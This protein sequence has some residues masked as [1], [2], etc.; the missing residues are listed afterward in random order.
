MK[1]LKQ[2]NY[3]NKENKYMRKPNI[4]IALLS[5]MLVGVLSS[6]EREFD[7]PP[8]DEI[9]VGGIVDVA[10]LRGM[11]T[12]TSVSFNQDM[13]LFATVTSD[14]STG[15][16]YKEAYI[17]DGSGAIKLRLLAAGGLYPGD[18]IRVYLKGTV[19]TEFNG[20]LQLDSV[21]VDK[22]IIKQAVGRHVEPTVMQLSDI[23]AEH[24]SKLVRIP[25]VEFVEN[26]LN[27]TWANASA[28]AAV[29]HNLT[30]CDGNKRLLRTSGY[31]NFAGQTIPSGHGYIT[32]IVSVFNSDLQLFINRPSDAVFNEPRCTPPLEFNCVPNNGLNETFENHSV[33]GIVTEHCWSSIATVGTLNWQIKSLNSNKIAEASIAGTGDNTN[34]MWMVSPEMVSGGND[35]LAFESACKNWKHDGLTVW[36]SKNFSG[37]IAS[38]TWIEVPATIA[39]NGTG[40]DIFIN[41]GNISLSSFLGSGYNGSYFVAF[42]YNASGPAQQTT[43][44]KVNNVV[45]TQ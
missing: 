20:L 4:G 12:G 37:N 15:N 28:L 26:E 44:F 13:S 1:R 27:S 25:N 16:F 8:I 45:I 18:S 24:Q 42:K 11:Y 43:T 30:D 40:N 7:R 6:C 21:N 29:N 9:P 17:Q 32:A 35:I 38:A 31:A 39:T 33:G 10:T 22:N 36:V 41:S 2:K 14:E 5:L 23:T 3:N 19:L 34:E